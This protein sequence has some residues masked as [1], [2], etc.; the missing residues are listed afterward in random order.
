[1]PP[2]SIIFA[3]ATGHT[4]DIAER[5]QVLLPESQLKDLDYLDSVA[6]FEDYDAL[7]CCTPRWNTGSDQKR[8]GTS[9]D[10]RI[11][12]IPELQLKDKPV[13]IVGLGDSAA[14]SKYFCDAMEELY[15]AFEKSGAKMIGHTPTTDYIFDGSKSVINGQFCG[16]PIDEDNESEK[17]HQRLEDWAQ[18]VLAESL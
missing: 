10:Q 8:S 2:L 11:L 14:F 13:A 15:R 6:E 4:E 7:V 18:Q 17:T 12:E 1:M 5:L 16:L 3:S 9:W